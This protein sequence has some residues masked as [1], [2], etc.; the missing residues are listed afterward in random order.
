MEKLFSR[1]GFILGFLGVMLLSIFSLQAGKVENQNSGAEFTDLQEAIDAASP[2]D[3]LEIKGKFI[4]NFTICKSLTISG[5]KG[6]VLNGGQVGTVLGICSPGNDV[7]T[8]VILD[9]FTIENGASGIEGGGGIVNLSAS[10]TLNRM[11][12]KHNQTQGD[13]G[14]IV[15][16]S[17]GTPFAAALTI[18][19]SKLSHNIA[20]GNG[21]G[22]ANEGGVLVM[23]N[24]TVLG[25]LADQTGGGIF[26]YFGQNTISDSTMAS[27]A[28][29]LQGGAL[30][31]IFSSTT[32]LT[33]VAIKHNNAGQ[34]GGIFN[35]SLPPDVPFFPST[36]VINESTFHGNSSFTQGGAL[37]NDTGATA[38]FSNSDISRN[39][40]FS[41][42]GGI[43]NNTG[44]VITISETEIEKNIPDNI[45]QL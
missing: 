31:N 12:V 39:E 6:A 30:E 42:G 28:A 15:M 21:G 5:K 41:T 25:N 23:E 11:K 8:F 45:T 26:S 24:S 40:A 44:G 10:V 14:G 35:G 37:F 4:G 3:V 13:G 1:I 19:N 17:V 33:K 32:T 9:H 27:N 18:Y 22:I 38:I 20:S 7:T 2:G 16:Y 43:L 34:A 36:V 29:V